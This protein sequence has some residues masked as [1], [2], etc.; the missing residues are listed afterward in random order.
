[1][2]P[3]QWQQ[4]DNLLH[5]VLD[6]PPEDRDAFLRQACGGDE[7]LEREV[8]SLLTAQEQAG[9]FLQ[10]PA[11]EVAAQAL[12]DHQN[13]DRQNKEGQKSNEILIG[14]IVSHYRITG[15][16]GSGGMGVVYQAEDQKL[17]R[18]VA[19]KLLPEATRQDPVALERFW[20]EARTASSL[21]HPGICTIYELNDT[22]DP[23]FIVMELL[24]GHSLDKIYGKSNG[25]RPIPY[26]RLLDFGIQAAD[27][28][29]AAHRKGIV[30]RDIKPSNI[31]MSPS[32]QTK[33]L[34]FGLAKLEPG[35]TIPGGARGNNASDTLAESLADRLLT[36]PGSAIGTIAYM[37]PEQARGENLDARSDVFSLGV[38][39]YELATGQHPFAGATTAVTFDRILNRAPT[40]PVTLNPELPVELEDTINKTL[41]KDRE[42]RLQSAA[43][44]RADLK[45]L[46][47]RISG[48]SASPAAATVSDVRAARTTSGIVPHPGK[49]LPALAIGILV[50]VLVLML[51]AGF[52]A[53]LLWPRAAPF[54]SFSVGQITNLGT[55]ENIALSADGKLLAEVKND[56]GQRTVWIR[57]MATN[58]D[59]QILS[60]FPQD[61]AG[62]SFSPNA[63]YLYFTRA[64]P[65]NNTVRA[66]YVMPLFGGTPRL[67]VNVVDSAPSFSPDGNRFA[68]VRWTPHRKDQ[69][70]E[71]HLADRDGGNDQLAYTT[72]NITRAPA[73]SPRGDQIAWI[74]ISGL[75]PAVIKVLD[76]SSKKE[77]S[78]A[79]PSGIFFDPPPISGRADLAWLPDGRH[80]LF[81]YDKAFSDRRQ[82]GVLG[83]PRGDFHTVT[84]DVNAYSQLA[85]SADGQSLATVLSNVDSSLAYYKGD[86]G[87][88]ISSTPLR[89]TPNSLAWADED[90]PFLITRHTGIS[91]LDRMTGSLQP[92]DTG[93]L[94]LGHYVSTCP[95]GQVLFTAGP[96]VGGEWRLFRMNGDGSGVTQLTTTGIARAPFCTPDGQ[97]VYFTIRDPARMSLLTLWSMPL[98]GGAPRKELEVQGQ[99]SVILSRDTRL[100]EAFLP[101]DP[102]WYAV[103]R[104]LNTQQILHRLPLDVNTL[105]R[106]AYPSFSPDG[107]AIVVVVTY[108]G[109]Y[110]L[111]YHPI[112]GSPSHLL[113]EPTR[114]TLTAFAWSPSGSKLGVLRLRMSSDV[115]LITDLTGKQP[116]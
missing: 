11:I 19:L 89:I 70:S 47:R 67:L 71:I 78:I 105:I 85:I 69:Y 12:A 74:E 108:Q 6:R 107:K 88:M 86:G 29:E 63:N 28:L 100:A 31:F 58:T 97:R 94:D 51:L 99:G 60:A 114:E 90:H 4:V 8:R 26:P 76:L 115:V 54:A 5:L 101:E 103:I 83:V 93:E 56:A 27:A 53:W 106:N 95:N 32:G 22:G 98:S 1:M 20:R 36:S 45:R 14:R 10:N 44:L 49:R 2:D 21:N 23:P 87:E 3:Q 92:I 52:A 80:L 50:P 57:N 41:E 72:L 65:E 59:A 7:A 109:G 75:T 43:E 111:R 73:W 37:S 33:I 25:R 104:D 112:D 64:T 66:V 77:V 82:I 102:V 9:S 35:Y 40:A 61:Y 48:G 81:L 113:T 55:L 17:G 39:L 30:H 15:K 34:D 46:Q 38:V 68:Y 79:Q 24:Q 116:H 42:L 91:K 13:A 110:A 84:N 62:L 96:K 16:L 18:S